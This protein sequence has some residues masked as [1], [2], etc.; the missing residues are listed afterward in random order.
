MP[1][2]W[3]AKIVSNEVNRKAKWCKMPIFGEKRTWK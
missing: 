2:L 1:L 3:P